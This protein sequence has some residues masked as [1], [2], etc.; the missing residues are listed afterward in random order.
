MASS[1]TTE[2]KAKGTASISANVDDDMKNISLTNTMHVPD[3]RTNLISVAKIT[4]KDY[5]VVFDSKEARVIDK[6]GDAK[7]IADI[8]RVQS[9]LYYVREESHNCKSITEKNCNTPKVNSLMFWHRKLGHLNSRD[10]RE[11]MKNEIVRGLRIEHDEK[12]TFSA[13]FAPVVK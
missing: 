7:L 12:A 8:N 4:D 1:A 2:I 6:N 3:L 13:K 11:A 9:G 10:L 5:T